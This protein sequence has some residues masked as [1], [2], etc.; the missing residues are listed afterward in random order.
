[1]VSKPDNLITTVFMGDSIT[2]GQFIDP[3]FK[4]ANLVNDQITRTYLKE[5]VTPIFVTS[6]VSGE[7]T[8]QGLER[9]PESVQNHNPDIVTIQFGLNDCNCWATDH[10]LPRVSL[11]AY[12]A[13]LVEMVERSKH[14]GASHIIL[15]NNHPTLRHKILLSGHSL[16]EKRKEYN[17]IANE[18][19]RETGAIFCD[20]D[21]A[22][23]HFNDLELETQLLPYPD[24]LHLSQQGHEIYAAKILPF[25][26][27]S[28]HA[29]AKERGIIEAGRRKIG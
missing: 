20:I 29:I 23:S 25:I 26:E 19:A 6:G 8:R 28:V 15:S 7:T 4:W 2:F 24:W 16:E 18:V 3:Q 10:G 13:N 1:M 14:F 27:A 5:A 22:F 11:D 9:F 21:S 17:E 12:R